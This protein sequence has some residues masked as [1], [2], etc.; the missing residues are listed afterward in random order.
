[1]KFLWIYLAA[2]S[3]VSVVVCIYDKFAAKHAKKHRTR[4]STLLLLSAV[5]GSVAMLLCMLLIRHKT[6]HTKFMVGIPAIIVAQL[7]LVA[8]ILFLF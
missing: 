5:G 8:T 3:L 4:E 1:M 2:I 7:A 6:K